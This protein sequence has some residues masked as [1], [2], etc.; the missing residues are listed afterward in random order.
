MTSVGKNRE[1]DRTQRREDVGEAR[2]AQEHSDKVTEGKMI[3][4]IT[5]TTFI[6]HYKLPF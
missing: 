6:L 2:E 5:I 4:S 3:H 1:E